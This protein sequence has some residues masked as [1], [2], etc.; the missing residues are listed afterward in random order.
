MIYV[1]TFQHVNKL[2]ARSKI[3]AWWVCAASI[4]NLALCLKA[5]AIMFYAL[6]CNH[7]YNK[8]GEPYCLF[9]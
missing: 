9:F 1:A 3:P 5:N 7:N 4:Q 8:L 6:F 2:F